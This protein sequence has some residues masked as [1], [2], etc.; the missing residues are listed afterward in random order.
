[1][2]AALRAHA[3]PVEAAGLAR[4]FKTGPGEYGEGDRFLGLHLSTV[5]AIAKEN[6]GLPVAELERLLESPYHEVRTT[7]LSIMHQEAS[8]ARTV[9][10]RRAELFEL[11]LRRH[12]RINNWDLVDLACRWVVGGYLMDKPR[13][14]LYRLARS[15]NVWERRTAMV[16]CWTFIRA[17]QAHDAVAIAEILVDDPHDLIRKATGWMLR[18]IGEVDPP[19]LVAFLDRHAASM[20][21]TTLRYAIEKFPRD[22]RAQWMSVR[23]KH[24]GTPRSAAKAKPQRDA[25]PLV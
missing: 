17:G 23:A 24:A 7:A 8:R 18:S 3:S 5:S 1:M 19:V 15:A 2:V 10:A 20:P 21:R 13:D 12:D 11:Y 16:S 4:Y 9:E 6:L 25:A 22:E 14:I